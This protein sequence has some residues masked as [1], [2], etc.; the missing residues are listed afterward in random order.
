LP[1][2]FDEKLGDEFGFLAKFINRALD[3]VAEQQR[4]YVKHS[5]V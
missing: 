2:R 3:S 5:R 1:A 4:N